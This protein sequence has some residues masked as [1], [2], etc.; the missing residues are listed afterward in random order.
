[1]LQSEIKGE[2]KNIE[3]YFD[4]ANPARLKQLD[5]LLLTQGWRDYIWKKFENNTIK[6]TYLPESEI[7]LTGMVRQK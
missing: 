1:M 6:I 5:L 4:S 7:T 2:I 3:K